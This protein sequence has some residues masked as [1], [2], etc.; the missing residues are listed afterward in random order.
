MELFA[1][2]AKFR[3]GPGRTLEPGIPA[4]LDVKLS[5]ALMSHWSLL[6]HIQLAPRCNQVNFGCGLRCCR[7]LIMLQ[8]DQSLDT[9]R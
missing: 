3:E 1:R 4:W 9:I 5:R 6:R 8:D 2:G 7:T